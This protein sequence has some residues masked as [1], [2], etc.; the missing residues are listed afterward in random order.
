MSQYTLLSYAFPV[1]NLQEK[2]LSPRT[3]QRN[4]NKG[5]LDLVAY[6]NKLKKEK[7]QLRSKP[8][9]TLNQ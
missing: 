7:I 8:P 1:L 4:V 6:Q 9:T 5:Y 3:F 2:T